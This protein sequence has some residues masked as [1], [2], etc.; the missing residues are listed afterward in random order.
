MLDS[1]S[2][3]QQLT[4][5]PQNTTQATLTRFLAPYARALSH[6]SRHMRA[7]RSHL[8]RHSHITLASSPH[9]QGTL[10]TPESPLQSAML[11]FIPAFTH[12]AHTFSRLCALCAHLP[13]PSH[14]ARACAFTY[15]A[16]H[17]I[18]PAFTHSSP[19]NQSIVQASHL[20]TLTQNSHYTRA[21]WGHSE[22]KEVHST[23]LQCHSV[24]Y[25]QLSLYEAQLSRA[26]RA[27]RAPFPRFTMYTRARVP[28][29]VRPIAPAIQMHPSTDHQAP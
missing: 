20:H 14:L 28:T 8:A 27:M 19:N 29:L 24:R 17:A 26:M 16:H 25:L 18:T 1:K 21:E 6:A 9:T 5:S 13:T 12:S 3:A 15:I 4:V 10:F 2:I 7:S 22:F 23:N 11:H